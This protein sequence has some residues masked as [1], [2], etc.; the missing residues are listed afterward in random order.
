MQSKTACIAVVAYKEFSSRGQSAT[1]YMYHITWFNASAFISLVP[2]SMWVLFKFDHYL[3][4]T[5]YVM[6]LFLRSIV[7]LLMSSNCLSIVHACIHDVLAIVLS[8]SL[9]DILNT[10]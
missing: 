7:G 3:F 4:I 1:G 8:V 9:N 2:K 6:P 5:N 10:C